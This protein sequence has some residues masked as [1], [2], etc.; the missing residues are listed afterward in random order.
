MFHN[1]RVPLKVPDNS[2]IFLILR[3]PVNPDIV[4]LVLFDNSN[5]NPLFLFVRPNVN[6]SPRD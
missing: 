4:P 6:A 3:L 2:L 5:N 1:M